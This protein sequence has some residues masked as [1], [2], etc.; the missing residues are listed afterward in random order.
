MAYT[1]PK[2][3]VQLAG[4]DGNAFAIMG[5]VSRGLL[6][7][8]ASRQQIAEYRRLAMRGDYDNLLRVSMEYTVYGGFGV[9]AGEDDAPGAEDDDERY[10]D[11]GQERA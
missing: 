4:E 8:G 11:I 6:V 3:R 1:G 9:G 5:L 7:V 2:A 10:A